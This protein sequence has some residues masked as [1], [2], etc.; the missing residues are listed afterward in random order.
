MIPSVSP[1]FNVKLTLFTA[2]AMPS[3]VWNSTSRSSTSSNGAE[4]SKPAPLSGDFL[5]PGS[6]RI[7]LFVMG[8]SPVPGIEGVTQ[9]VA[10]HDEAQ[11]RD[12]DEGA[13][14]DQQVPETRE[15]EVLA[16]VDQEPP[17]HRGS[18]VADAEVGQ[19]RLG[20]DNDPQ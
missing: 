20:A 10:Q 7:S 6:I 18:L 4:R 3:R 8:F 5:D 19:R 12:D 9:H 16:L 2:R 13:G 1:S 11:D 17:G 14:N 15:R